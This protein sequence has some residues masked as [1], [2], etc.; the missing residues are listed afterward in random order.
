M[1]LTQS[2]VSMLVQQL[3]ETLGLKLFDR[4]AAVHADRRRPA[5]APFCAPHPR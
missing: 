4:G 5:I 3:E 1:S 2:A